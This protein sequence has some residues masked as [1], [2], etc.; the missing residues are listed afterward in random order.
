MQKI[1]TNAKVIN[2]NIIYSPVFYT[3]R[4]K[5]TSVQMVV[6][7]TSAQDS[8]AKAYI[9]VSN[10]GEEWFNVAI[11]E[12]DGTGLQKDGGPYEALWEYTRILIEKTPE[13]GPGRV[14]VYATIR[15]TT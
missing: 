2:G 13:H 8:D 9:Q 4:A 7:S 10:N 14:N 15:E 3:G 12:T 1:I 5:R 11:L 6:N